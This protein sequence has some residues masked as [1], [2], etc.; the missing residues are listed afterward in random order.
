MY[1]LIITAGIVII[2]L[3]PPVLLYALRKPGWRAQPEAEQGTAAE[4]ES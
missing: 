3:L 2:G 1:A 4:V